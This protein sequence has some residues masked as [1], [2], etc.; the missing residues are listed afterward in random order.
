MA[1]YES[2][3]MNDELKMYRKTVREFLQAEFL[4]CRHRGLAGATSMI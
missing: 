3:W 1:A 2:P 4:P